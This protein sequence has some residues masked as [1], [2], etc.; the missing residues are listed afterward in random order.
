MTVSEHPRSTSGQEMSVEGRNLMHIN[1]LLVKK[2]LDC[3]LDKPYK[4]GDVIDFEESDRKN[5]IHRIKSELTNPLIEYLLTELLLDLLDTTVEGLNR[6]LDKIWEIKRNRPNISTDELST[7]LL[8]S[9][10]NGKEDE[11]IIL[12]ILDD[13]KSAQ[14]LDMVKNM[15]KDTVVTARQPELFDPNFI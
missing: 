5:V 6:D 11:E 3:V 2:V 7:L 12:S 8:L 14:V 13:E 1:F 9:E 15:P 10:A 4:I